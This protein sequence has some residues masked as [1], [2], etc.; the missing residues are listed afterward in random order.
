MTC[1]ILIT[2]HNNYLE[3][4]GYDVSP[5]CHLSPSLLTI[6]KII[7]VS[8]AGRDVNPNQILAGMSLS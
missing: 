2:A 8:K 1:I 7:I 4:I 3:A 5:S 6:N